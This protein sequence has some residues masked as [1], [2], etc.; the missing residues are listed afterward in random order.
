MEGRR[1]YVDYEAY[2]VGCEIVNLPDLFDE[3]ARGRDWFITADSSRPETISHMRS[4]GFPKMNGAIKGAKSLEEGVAFLQSFEIVVNPRCRHVIDEL[5]SY[6]YKVDPLTN[7]ALPLLEDKNNHC[8]DALRYACEAVRRAKQDSYEQRQTPHNN[9]RWMR[10]TLCAM[11]PL[12]MGFVLFRTRRPTFWPRRRREERVDGRRQAD[13]LLTTAKA[14]FKLASEKRGTTTAR[15]WLEDVKFR[16]IG[17]LNQWPE[18]IKR[19][20]TAEDKQ[21]SPA[22]WWTS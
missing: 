7:Q 21:S 8:I 6:K 15:S 11:S 18:E 20:R 2:M 14:H 22:S 3:R 1:L 5:A 13:S 19:A 17:Q 4:H 16:V 10:L 12:R 9:E